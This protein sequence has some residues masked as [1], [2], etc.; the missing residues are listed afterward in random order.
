MFQYMTKE[1]FP[2]QPQPDVMVMEQLEKALE[3]WDKQY[4]PP[5]TPLAKHQFPLEFMSACVD[6]FIKYNTPVLSSAAVERLFSMGSDILRPKRSALTANNFEKLVFLKGNLH[7]LNQ[8]KW[9][10]EEEEDY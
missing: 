7:M 9:G 8:K 5:T 3:A 1:R 4:V 6:L 2:R 10:E